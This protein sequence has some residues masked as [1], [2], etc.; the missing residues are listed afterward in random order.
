MSDNKRPPVERADPALV[1]RIVLQIVLLVASAAAI[2]WLLYTLRAVL[3]LLAF[4]IIFCY[5]VAPL[6]E[7]V[8]GPLRLGSQEFRVPHTL[9]I[10]IVYLLLL[11]GILFALERVVPLLSEQLT[12]LFENFPVY[13]RQLDQQVKWLASLPNRYRL[14]TSL[15]ESLDGSINAIIPSIFNWAQL[16]ATKA[17][18]VTFYLPWL[19]LIPIIGFFFLKD[20]DVISSRLLSSFPEADRRYR[21]A[22]FL[23]DVS[24]T[25]AAYMRGQLLACLLVGMIEGTG[26]WLLGVSYPLVLGVAAGLF[27]FVPIVGPLILGLIAILVASFYSWRSALL[28]AVFLAVYRIIHDYVIYPRLLGQR[29]EIHPVVVIL[30]VLCGVELGGVT[31]VFLSIPAVALLIVSWR[32]WRELQ[33]DRSSMLVSTEETPLIESVHLQ[34]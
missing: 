8:E 27:E 33:L 17:V 16:V 14:P 6:V 34:D 2:A 23:R 12:A 13:A 22:L 11:G 26:F 24:A 4:T 9:A 21:V 7:F 18:Q 30:A 5:L 32:H 19:V 10:V 3:L 31:G 1:R 25:L 28:I 15:R 20:A 29:M